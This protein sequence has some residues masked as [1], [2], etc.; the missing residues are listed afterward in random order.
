MFS[1]NKSKYHIQFCSLG[2]FILFLYFLL[3]NKAY[4]LIKE[5]FYCSLEETVII[6]DAHYIAN[7]H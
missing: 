2:N 7:I 1:E 5:R 3:E 6:K 4:I